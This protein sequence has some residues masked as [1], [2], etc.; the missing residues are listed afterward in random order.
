MEKSEK[1]KLKK[2]KSKLK[3]EVNSKCHYRP[4]KI[5]YKISSRDTY[6]EL[7]IE[8]QFLR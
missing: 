4:G 8:K 5:R 6:I 3:Y 1:E 7:I 2:L